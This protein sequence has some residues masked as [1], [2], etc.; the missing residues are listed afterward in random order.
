MSL[1]CRYFYRFVWTGQLGFDRKQRQRIFPLTFASKPV[2][3]PTTTPVQ[4]VGVFSLEI[5]R[6]Q[7]VMLATHPHLVPR[8]KSR[9]YAS[10][11]PKHHP[12]CV[13]N[14]LFF[15]W[16]VCTCHMSLYI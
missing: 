8:L 4:W 12:W 2:L 13:G 16:V 11:F 3:E 5:Q 9:S 14:H 1:F 10:S 7:D 6:S 15:V